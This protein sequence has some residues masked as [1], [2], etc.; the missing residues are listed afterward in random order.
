MERLQINLLGEFSVVIGHQ[1]ITRFRWA[2]SR[3]LL[4]YLAAQPRRDRARAT[5]ATL[6]WVIAG[7]RGQDQSAHR[8][9]EPAQ[10]PGRPSGAGHRAQQRA[11]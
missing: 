10:A 3:A 5:L 7:E 4:A 1:A 9:I 6:L 2:K 8:A 11:F